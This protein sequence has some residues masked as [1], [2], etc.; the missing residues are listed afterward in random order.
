MARIDLDQ[1]PSRYI[2]IADDL[3]AQILA[4]R[5]GASGRLPTTRDL[6][7]TIGVNR[8]TVVAA[9]AKL[10]EWGLAKAHVGRGTFALPPMPDAPPENP[11]RVSGA[12]ISED[13][14]SMHPSTRPD[15]LGA[16]SR[17]MG[18]RGLSFLRSNTPWSG[19]F[20]RS[21]EG[22]HLES[23]A[24]IYSLGTMKGAISFAGSFPALELLPRAAFR[25]AIDKALGT[26]PSRSLAYGPAQGS[27]PLREWIAEDMTRRGMPTDPDEVLITNG[28]QQA[29]D[30][31]ARAFLDRGDLVLLENPTYSGAISTFHS[32]GA[33]LAG[34]PMDG[35]G[36]VS[37]AIPSRTA[38]GGAKLLYTIPSFQNPTAGVMSEPRRRQILEEAAAAG[39]LVIEDDWASDLR[40]EGIDP[41]TLRS[42]DP[43]GRVIYVSTFAK[44][45]IPS[46]RIGWIAAAKP[47]V[48]RLTILKQINDCCTSPLIQ[49][50]LYHFC[51]DASLDRHLHRV[52]RTYRLRR[53]K[54][55]AAMERHFPKPTAWSTPPG[56][57]FLWV[58]LPEG[59]DSSAVA[60]DAEQRGV[61]VSRG[62]PF[63]LDGGGQGNLRLT[64]ASSRPSEIDAGVR[65]LGSL[66]REHA[67]SAK[68]RPRSAR[69]EAVPLV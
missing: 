29:I 50:A 67:S 48:E 24:A 26:R 9:Y 5:F 7:R 43:D 60:A 42:L 34:L 58:R 10:E 55:I 44:K 53:D 25:S 12:G 16:R 14:S 27:L 38:R 69:R 21:M 30:L 4:G 3:K 57:L 22:G 23:L 2:Q 54:M 36:L 45:L 37:G 32:F 41:P 19:L 66:L 35:E 17:G 61:L 13:P 11:S 20:S 33:R 52:R 8:N 6:A 56:G 15:G 68:H 51:K 18:R 64:F 65:R 59:V 39:L 62:E 28:S 47:I 46:L 1:S 31:I 63:H 40:F 49:A